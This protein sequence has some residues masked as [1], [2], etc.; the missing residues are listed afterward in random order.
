MTN[1]EEKIASL[2]GKHL[3]KDLNSPSALPYQILPSQSGGLPAQSLLMGFVN[4]RTSRQVKRGWHKEQDVAAFCYVY[5]DLTWPRR[6][7]L[8]AF[9]HNPGF[10][11][12]I[13]RLAYA[14][15]LAK[16]VGSPVGLADPKLSMFSGDPEASA[17]LN[18]NRDVLKLAGTLA[19]TEREDT[20]RTMRID[21]HLRIYPAPSGSLLVLHTLPKTLMIRETLL[22]S[23]VLQLASAVE[24]TL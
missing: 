22:A 16:A 10:V 19:V 14:V 9:I 15:P 12:I 13:H 24:A 11:T 17:K 6:F 23:E 2:V 21:R 7:A 1:K 8:Q 20:D 3:S 4:G 5:F 18:G